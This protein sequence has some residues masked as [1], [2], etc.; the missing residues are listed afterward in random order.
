PSPSSL[1]SFSSI[2]TE[3]TH[4]PMLVIIQLILNVLGKALFEGGYLFSALLS[5]LS[6]IFHNSTDL[7]CVLL[8]FGREFGEIAIEEFTILHH[9]LS[10][11]LEVLAG[12]AMTSSSI[13]T[14]TP[15]VAALLFC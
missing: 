9:C 2:S 5:A 11:S 7:N 15:T 14:A 4:H 12:S 13:P 8:C 1:L 10:H 6:T 3:F